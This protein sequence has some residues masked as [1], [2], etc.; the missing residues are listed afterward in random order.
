MTATPFRAL[1]SW[2][3]WLTVT[4][5]LCQRAQSQRQFA[6]SK[7]QAVADLCSFRKVFTLVQRAHF[8]SSNIAR[9]EAAIKVYA[10]FARLE[11]LRADVLKKLTSMLLHPFPRVCPISPFAIP[12]IEPWLTIC[13]MCR[14]VLVSRNTCSW[15]RDWIGSSLGIGANSQKY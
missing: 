14:S 9:L 2:L 15:R 10:A 4:F 7:I 11:P 13:P 6:V 12:R 1:N 3:S 8:K 5:S